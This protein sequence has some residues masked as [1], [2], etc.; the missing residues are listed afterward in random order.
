[1]SVVTAAGIGASVG[2]GVDV[3]AGS[4]AGAGAGAWSSE[5]EAVR[6][7]RDKAI[8]SLK[9][10]RELDYCQ[11]LN[12]VLPRDVRAVAWCPVTPEFSARFS[13]VACGVWCVVSG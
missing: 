13:G 6:R 5:D 8:K 3:G 4:G 10:T 12:R 11:T 7:A 2:V 1:M 9:K